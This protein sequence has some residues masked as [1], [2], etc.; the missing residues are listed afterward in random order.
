MK[1]RSAKAKG[2]RLEVE[3]VKTIE[4]HGLKV[5]RQP[6]SGIYADFPHD[7]ELVIH[8]KRYI[9]ECKARKNGF[10]TLDRWRG[11]ADLLVVKADREP[12]MVYLPLR[13]FSEIIGT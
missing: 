4:A 1:A 3:V 11:A 8:G 7:V 9:V 6:G 2:T 10:A 13:L 12:P 5:R